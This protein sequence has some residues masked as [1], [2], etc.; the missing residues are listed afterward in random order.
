MTPISCRG[1]N[2]IPGR[3]RDSSTS[4]GGQPGPLPDRTMARSGGWPACAAAA[5]GRACFWVGL[6]Y[7]GTRKPPWF[8]GL[9]TL[10]NRGEGMRIQGIGP[11]SRL[12]MG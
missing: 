1:T 10:P 4:G 7:G 11:T 2:P 9:R 5:H 8:V 6:A 3:N 12:Q